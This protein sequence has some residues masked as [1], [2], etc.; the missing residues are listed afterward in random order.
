M[1][2][3]KLPRPPPRLKFEIP[4]PPPPPLREEALSPAR[5]SLELASSGRKAAAPVSA[6]PREIPMPPRR[7]EA[8]SAPPRETPRPPD[9]APVR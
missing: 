2:A 1:T 4:I 9:F 8:P 5:R 7:P 6:P 3:P